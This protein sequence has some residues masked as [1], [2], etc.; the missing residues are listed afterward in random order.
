MRTLKI[1]GA[2]ALE[3]ERKLFGGALSDLV[4]SYARVMDAGLYPETAMFNILGSY[5][6]VII[7][8]LLATLANI[9]PAQLP[10]HVRK[11]ARESLSGYD[12]EGAK[13]L[14]LEFPE[15]IAIDDFRVMVQAFRV[16]VISAWN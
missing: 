15:T 8:T 13:L 1:R 5:S 12:A 2:S 3:E 7:E 14:G 9:C 16:Y 10:I 4:S 6:P 11:W